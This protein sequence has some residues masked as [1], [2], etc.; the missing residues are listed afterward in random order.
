[1]DWQKVLGEFNGRWDLCFGCG[2][3]NPIGLKL[4]FKWDGN[5]ACGE[6]T[7]KEE[8]QG[9]PGVL[10]GGII[11]NIIDE[12]ASWAFN[13]EGIF[14][15]TAKM[16]ILFHHPALIG[17]TLSIASNI[18]AKNGKRGSAYTRITRKD[19]TLIAEGNSLHVGINNKTPEIQSKYNLA[20]IFDMDGVIVDTADFHFKSWQYAF[21]KAGVDFKRKD[22]TGLFGRRNDAIIRTVLKREVSPQEIEQIAGEKEKYFLENVAGHVSAF[23][24][25]IELIKDLAGMGIKTAIASSAPPENIQLLL[26][27]LDIKQYFQQFVSGIEVTESKPSPL[28]YLLAAR[29]L[30][31]APENCIVFEDAV[32]GVTGAK[33]GGMHCVGFTS[34]N[35]REN[36]QEAD[37]VVDSLE[38]VSVSSLV[39]LTVKS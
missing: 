10:H 19:G 36:L 35:S 25:A 16:E 11:A 39:K 14:V 15:V 6:F 32:A 2:Q 37:L 31:I 13:F 7:P 12:A 4:N 9:W 5:G 18:T 3:K 27:S 29:K 38:E 34:T 30:G 23:P 33:R 26:S 17:E 1:M 22:F 24:G 20:V 21:K 28:I 8:F